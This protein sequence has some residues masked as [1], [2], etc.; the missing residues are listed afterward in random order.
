VGLEWWILRENEL[1]RGGLASNIV[2]Y[3]TLNFYPQ[4]IALS[5]VALVTYG[6]PTPADGR[7]SRRP[8]LAG[9]R[10]FSDFRQQQRLGAA[11]VALARLQV[12]FGKII[13]TISIFYREVSYK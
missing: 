2:H 10:F 6:L 13:R 12:V 9:R 7:V 5:F 1:H 3:L 11:V 8:P 4:A